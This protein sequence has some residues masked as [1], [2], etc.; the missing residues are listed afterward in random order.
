MVVL[1]RHQVWRSGL[2]IILVAMA[3]PTS[4]RAGQD[5]SRQAPAGASLDRLTIVAPGALTGGWART[6][7]K[8]ARTLRA[9][10]LVED[11]SVVHRQG[12]SGSLALAEFVRGYRGN[13]KALLVGGSVMLGAAPAS[14][15]VGSNFR[16]LIP[17]AR[18]TGESQ[19]LATSV[20][21]KYHTL[22]DLLET[23]RLDPTSILWVGGSYGGSNH[24]AV[25]MI[26]EATASEHVRSNFVPTQSRSDM[27]AFVRDNP[28]SIGVGGY[29][30]FEPDVA[31]GRLR[32][33][34]MTAGTR[35]AGI[36]VPT[37]VEA[38]VD[39]VFVNWRGVFAAP[40][41]SAAEQQ[42][43]ADLMARMVKHPEWQVVLREQYWRDLYQGSEE[44][45]RF[46]ESVLESPAVRRTVP[47]LHWATP[48]NG[49]PRWL[50]V[51]LPLT[52]L[53]ALGGGWLWWRR[54]KR[55]ALGREQVLASSL[56]EARLDAERHAKTAD[57]LLKGMGNAIERQLDAWALTPA[58]KEVAELLLKGM[59]HKEIAE[60]RHTSERT[61][62]Q[63]GLSI[64]R[65]AGV[66]SRTELAAYF[67]EDLI[68]SADKT[69]SDGSRGH[70]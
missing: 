2:A 14:S 30:E 62:R 6:A 45:Q 49:G 16:S 56:E 57:E 59:R 54:Q 35:E 65:K 61:V 68:P 28:T 66:E 63:Q 41:T 13:G 55:A 60:V 17:I 42:R 7:E 1:T 22:D 31:A 34:G 26:A 11:V 9:S 23:L 50:T 52:L 51:G 69:E 36:D 40:G 44:F 47:L 20:G 32:V 27:L 53:A 58:E 10:G 4:G 29:G 25:S 5:A 67:L 19:A 39:V 43:L 70:A 24:T 15:P 33:L 12:D 37:L 3:L 18:L 38:G 46:L 64:Y 8:I 48:W 21:S